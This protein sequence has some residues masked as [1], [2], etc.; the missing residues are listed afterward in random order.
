MIL[1]LGIPWAEQSKIPPEWINVKRIDGW[2][3]KIYSNTAPS[4][5]Y[6]VGWRMQRRGK[7]GQECNFSSGPA[8]MFLNGAHFPIK[9]PIFA[10]LMLN[11]P[12][13][14]KRNQCPSKFRGSLHPSTHIQQC[15]SKHTRPSLPYCHVLS[16]SFRYLFVSCVGRSNWV[17]LK[18][19]GDSVVGHWNAIVVVD[20]SLCSPV[21]LEKRYSAGGS[22][23]KVGPNLLA[24]TPGGLTLRVVGPVGLGLLFRGIRRK[25]SHSKETKTNTNK[26]FRVRPRY[27]MGEFH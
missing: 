12:T 18:T 10:P 23:W 8:F 15:A 22:R 26:S 7:V 3:S 21:S 4:L 9:M 16:A 19:M 2:W 13:S 17:P 5:P 6:Q 25:E 20:R 24:M 11:R 14:D 1:G 27:W